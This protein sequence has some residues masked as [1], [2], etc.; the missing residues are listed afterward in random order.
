M[1]PSPRPG[2]RPGSRSYEVT[3]RRSLRKRGPPDGGLESLAAL[4]PNQNTEERPK[5]A[6]DRGDSATPHRVASTTLPVPRRARLSR[7]DLA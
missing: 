2:E 4:E 6:G 7:Y 5:P 3:Q 1:A